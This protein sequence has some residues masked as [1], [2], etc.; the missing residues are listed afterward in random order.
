MLVAVDGADAAGKTTFADDLAPLVPAGRCGRPSTT[1]TT[2]G[3]IGTPQGRTGAT[4][5]ER[6]FD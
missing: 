6:G 1:S 4:V 2:R 5:W 3:P